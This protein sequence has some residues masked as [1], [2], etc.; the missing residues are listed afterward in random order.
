MYLI[1]NRTPIDSSFKAVTL[2]PLSYYDDN[3]KLEVVL[4]QVKRILERSDVYY[5]LYYKPDKLNP[6]SFQ[7]PDKS[8]NNVKY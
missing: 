8:F 3:K 6:Q 7:F 5:A 2:M 1:V 4:H